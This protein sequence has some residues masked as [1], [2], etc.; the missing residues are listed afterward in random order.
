M[1]VNDFIA[2][3]KI[4]SVT[5]QTVTFHVGNR[6]VKVQRQKEQDGCEMGLEVWGRVH[7]SIGWLERISTK[8][9]D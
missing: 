8:G 7:V 4:L 6:M 2:R 3:I 9:S 1:G 5:R